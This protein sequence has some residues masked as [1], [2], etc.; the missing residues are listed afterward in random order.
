MGADGCA[1]DHLNVTIMCGGDGVHH[2]IPHSGLSPSHEAV[3]ASGARAIAVRQVAPRCTGS[4]HPE[5]AVQ[6]TSV[7]DAW[8]ASRFVGQQR[9]DHAPLK[10]GQ[11]ISA[12]ADA[13][14]QF[15][16]E[17]KSAICAHARPRISLQTQLCIACPSGCVRSRA[18]VDASPSSRQI[19]SDERTG[20]CK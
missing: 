20:Q 4:Q 8:N 10:V 19:L 1:V 2:P 5:D 6:H 13:E 3:V 17:A 16:L 7:I 18:A 12:H 15:R 11:I 14:S 9:F